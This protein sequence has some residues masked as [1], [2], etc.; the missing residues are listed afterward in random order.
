[1]YKYIETL[2]NFEYDSIVKTTRSTKCDRKSP[3]GNG[4]SQSGFELVLSLKP[5]L[6][7]F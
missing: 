7:R 5:R 4:L 1:M 6:P 3:H 2:R